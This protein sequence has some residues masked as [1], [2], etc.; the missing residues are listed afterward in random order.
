MQWIQY[1][2]D[3]LDWLHGSSPAWSAGEQVSMW[4][5]LHLLPV[6]LGWSFGA[7]QQPH[8]DFSLAQGPQ[9]SEALEQEY[10]DPL[11]PGGEAASSD[12]HQLAMWL[13]VPCP[14]HIQPLLCPD[15]YPPLF[16]VCLPFM[17]MTFIISESGS[18]SLTGFLDCTIYLSLL[19]FWL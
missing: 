4:N 13:P 12:S 16:P 19:F 8:V 14:G 3:V 17:F 11:K 7:A 18:F 1:S 15:L 2:L 9:H 10:H 6:L 5:C